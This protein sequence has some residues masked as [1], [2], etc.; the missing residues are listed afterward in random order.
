MPPIVGWRP[1]WSE[2][3]K[4]LVQIFVDLDTGST[5]ATTVSTRRASWARWESTHEVGPAHKE[6]TRRHDLDNGS[7]GH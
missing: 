2:D 1:L 7:N 3:R 6:D 4:T 5:L